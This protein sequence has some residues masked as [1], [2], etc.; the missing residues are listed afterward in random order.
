MAVNA[1]V[2]ALAKER[3]SLSLYKLAES[4]SPAEQF[5]F[6]VSFVESE[7]LADYA[8]ADDTLLSFVKAQ[9]S[10]YKKVSYWAADDN[11][12]WPLNPKVS[13]KMRKGFAAE[14][15]SLEKWVNT[16]INE[17]VGNLDEYK[18]QALSDKFTVLESNLHDANKKVDTM[19]KRLANAESDAEKE[20]AQKALDK[21]IA[22]AAA[23]QQARDEAQKAHDELKAATE[24]LD[25]V[26]KSQA[27][28]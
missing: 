3:D 25:K 7:G 24:A 6:L 11:F 14:Q 13:D 8:C 21:A 26:K 19:K 15:K 27:K 20:K 9:A 1:K 12:P 22:K 23:A 16:V 10:R 17:I 18:V 4:D 5:D 2:M 28:K